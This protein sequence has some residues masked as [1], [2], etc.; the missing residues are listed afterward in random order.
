MNKNQNK[1][2]QVYLELQNVDNVEYHE[3]HF[4]SVPV[5]SS[6]PLVRIYNPYFVL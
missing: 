5:Y 2:Y 6:P 3:S 4:E 1:I